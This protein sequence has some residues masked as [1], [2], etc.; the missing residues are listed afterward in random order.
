MNNLRNNSAHLTKQDLSFDNLSNC[1]PP[2]ELAIEVNYTSSVPTYHD[3][4]VDSAVSGHVTSNRATLSNVGPS[5]SIGNVITANGDSLN[6]VGHAT[7]SLDN[8]KSV[9]E[10]LYVPGIA[11]NLIS[12]GQL[13]NAGNVM[14]FDSKHC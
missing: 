4:Y 14:V 12:V 9:S 6:V 1:T 5:T 2:S 3:W 10:V 13:T 8:N 11:R 7:L